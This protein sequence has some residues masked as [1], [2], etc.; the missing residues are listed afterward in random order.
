MASAKGNI[1]GAFIEFKIKPNKPSAKQLGWMS[2]LTKN[3]FA[4][5]VCYELEE[6]IKF[7]EGYLK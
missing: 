4:C 6:A 2:Q 1:H 5:V 3:G 7:T